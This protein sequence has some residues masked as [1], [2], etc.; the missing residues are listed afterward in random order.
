MVN[1]KDMKKIIIKIAKYYFYATSEL[2]Q[3]L[4]CGFGIHNYNYE[5]KIFKGHDTFGKKYDVP[6]DCREC[7][8]CKKLQVHR[9]YNGWCGY[10][11]F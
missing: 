6:L 3:I 11:D 8:R 7:Q 10:E 1:R 2:L 5:R 4:A 9:C